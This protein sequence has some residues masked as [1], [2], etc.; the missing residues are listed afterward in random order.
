MDA[1]GLSRAVRRQLGLGRVLPLGDAADGAWLVESAAAQVLSAAALRELPDVRIG[2]LRLGPAGPEATDPPAVPPPPSA[3]PPGPLRIEVEF[4]ATP[5]APLTTTAEL[6]RAAL[7]RAAERELGLRVVT[8]DLRITDLVG[9][10]DGHNGHQGDGAAGA[11]PGG[12]RDASRTDGDASGRGGAHPRTEDGAP[13]PAPADDPRGTATAQ[14]V[15]SV[16]GVAR[17]APVLGSVLGGLPADAVTVTD[18]PADDGGTA[19]RHVRI[20][21]A[22]AEGA[23]ALDVAR[24]VREAAAKAA[25]WDAD[26]PAVPVT[27]AV[28]VSAVDP[29]GTDR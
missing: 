11:Q 5:H 1:E 15:L 21:L 8:V 14:A 10:P 9:A 23:R 28:L 19:H 20:Q 24:S 22:V 4:E 13:P 12:T 7:F 18:T 29:A 3:L 17:L 16:P 26:E 6:L 25:A 27:V 2:R